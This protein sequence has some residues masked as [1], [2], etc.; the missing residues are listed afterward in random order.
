MSYIDSEKIFETPLPIEIKW[1]CPP[2]SYFKLNIDGAYDKHITKGGIGGVVWD[3]NGN[4]IMVFNGSCNA[5]TA[6]HSELLA[7][8]KGLEKI[9][10]H[11]FLPLEVEVDSTNIFLILDKSPPLYNFIVWFCRLL[12]RRLGIVMT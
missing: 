7:L 8:Q 6:L 11:N 3:S 12:L 10:T 9:G 2:T 5:H 4:W 1:T